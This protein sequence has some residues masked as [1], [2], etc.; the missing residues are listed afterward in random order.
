MLFTLAMVVFFAAICCFF[1]QEFI[2]TFKRIF[3]IKGATIILPIA[4]ASWFVFTFDYWLL[5][6]VYYIREVLQ[7]GVASLTYIIPFNNEVASSIALITV[8]TAISVVPVFIL[9]LYIRKK[10]YKPYPYPYITS[11]LIWISATVLLVVL[12]GQN[13]LAQANIGNFVVQVT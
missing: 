8:L 7:K 9:N 6:A 11:T 3:A 4:F 1:S 12:D 13:S 10:T 5:W 2:K